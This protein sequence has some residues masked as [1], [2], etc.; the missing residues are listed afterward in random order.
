MSEVIHR[1][2]RIAAYARCRDEAGR[3]LL[4]RASAVS[5]N[6][7]RWF[8]PGG[9]VDHG[10]HPAQTVVREVAEETGLQV[11]VSGL[12]DV[13]TDVELLPDGT[14]RH[15][16]RLIF[17]ATIVGGAL[18]AELDGSTDQVAW[19]DPTDL[20]GLPLMPHVAQA[21]GVAHSAAG[22]THGAPAGGLPP[23][24]VPVDA[25]PVDA[26]DGT[27][28]FQRFAAYGLVRDPGQ[29]VLLTLIATGYPGAGLWHLPG[30][31]TDFGENAADGLL[32][33][34]WEE[35]DQRAR[36]TGVLEVSHRRHDHALGPEGVPIDWHGVRVVFAARVDEP[37]SPV[38]VE[39]AGST[40]AAGWFTP[41][42]ARGLTLTEVARDMIRT[43]IL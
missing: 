16:D 4:V 35:S 33:E 26:G 18:R 32:R 38:V 29:R 6:A 20:A 14:L 41:E 7:G 12:G 27:L 5:V 42:Q 19:V 10:E 37:T 36:I 3:V 8:L 1:W 9:G 2:R 39:R 34:I 31:G 22:P 23:G 11:T 40:E 25:G 30:G 15:Q 24:A 21:L 43:Y 13:V 28:R 17:D